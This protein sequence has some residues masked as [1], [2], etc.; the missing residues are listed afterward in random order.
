MIS[1]RLNS[2]CF[3]ISLDS[4]A[5]RQAMTSELGSS[6]LAALV[7]ERC[8]YLFSARPVFISDSQTVRMAEVVRAVEAVVALPAYREHI[9]ANAPAIARHD[10]GG[11]QG[12]F[13]GYDFHLREDR[14]G[15]IEINTNAG[16]AMLNAVMARAHYACCLDN[17]QLASAAASAAALEKNIVDMFF[18]EWKLSHRDRPLQ[19]IAIVDTQPQQQYLYPEF[20][21]FQQLFERH[22]L[23]AVIADPSELSLQ[24]G[25]LRHG[26]ISIDLVY[27]R[28]TD[29]MLESPASA[30]LRTAYLEQAA[31]LT[32][33]P[34]AHAL[35]ADKRN[36]AMLCDAGLLQALGVPRHVQEILL[37][38]I[39]RTEVVNAAHAERLWNA[40]RHL[41][42]KPTAGYGGRAAYRCDKLTKRVW[43]DILAAD[44]VAQALVAP[45]ERVIGSRENPALLKFDLRSYA[46]GGTVQWTAARM[47]QGQTTNFRTPGGGFAPVYS[48]P[49][50]DVACEIDAIAKAVEGAMIHCGKHC[51]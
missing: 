4:G 32:P 13:F 29:F 25:V 40:R 51:I 38:N 41:F 46:Y 24:E 14:I 28:L 49:D 26:A 7:E 48:L 42:F 30:A 19:T 22:G 11:A 16:G 34:Q 8:P 43:Q 47:Y 36:L 44:Y 18:N 6:E 33:H 3:C 1:E 31:V 17:I 39:P 12:V 10:P 27:N 45:G 50:A 15:L 9:F 2:Q 35:Y 20:L 23:R 5:L 37:A 21:L